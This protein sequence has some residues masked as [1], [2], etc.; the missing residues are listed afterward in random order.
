MLFVAHNISSD[1]ALCLQIL[2]DTHL[3]LHAFSL[4][5]YN[6]VKIKM[7][8]LNYLQSL[9]DQNV[10]DKCQVALEIIPSIENKPE[11][12]DQEKALITEIKV[13]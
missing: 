4:A 7:V 5:E 11:L 8:N 6:Y 3:K 12:T 9:I 13:K 10:V 1:D 2:A